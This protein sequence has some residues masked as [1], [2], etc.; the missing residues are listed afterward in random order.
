MVTVEE[1]L[2]IIIRTTRASLTTTLVIERLR[3]AHTTLV[4]D[5]LVR[6]PARPAVL[7][8]LSLD[9]QELVYCI[10]SKMPLST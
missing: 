1:H 10:S 5:F 9:V 7:Y 4:S 2:A 3:L 8:F 6:V